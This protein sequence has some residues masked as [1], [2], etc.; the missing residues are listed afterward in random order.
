M[1]RFLLSGIN[2]K[3]AAL[4]LTNCFVP[5]NPPASPNSPVTPP[6]HY[7]ANIAGG[8]HRTRAPQ[9]IKSALVLRTATNP[10]TILLML[11]R[12][13]WLDRTDP[14]CF[15]KH[16]FFDRIPGPPWRPWDSTKAPGRWSVINRGRMHAPIA[17]PTLQRPHCQ[18]PFLI[19]FDFPRFFQKTELATTKATEGHR[20]AVLPLKGGLIFSN[21]GGQLR[22]GGAGSAPEARFENT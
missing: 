13:A 2:R 3:C 12:H 14:T 9:K 19:I 16:A 5:K 15:Q 10:R 6:S 1:A 20:G 21:S 18:R 22:R 7:I 8:L 4:S 11:A 17:P